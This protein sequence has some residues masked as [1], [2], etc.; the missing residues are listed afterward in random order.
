MLFFSNVSDPIEGKTAAMTTSSTTTP[1]KIA[2][3]KCNISFY[4]KF[5]LLDSIDDCA[6][7]YSNNVTIQGLVTT[8]MMLPEHVTPLQKEM[9]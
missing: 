9:H 4:R 2:G 3:N 8:T 1:N 6:Y 5:V 7:I